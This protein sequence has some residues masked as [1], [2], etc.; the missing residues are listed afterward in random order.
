MNDL[1]EGMMRIV[2][3]PDEQRV[4][5]AWPTVPPTSTTLIRQTQMVQQGAN[6]ASPER[7]FSNGYS[8]STTGRIGVVNGASLDQVEVLTTSK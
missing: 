1:P 5:K 7:R 6:T 2:S 3:D 4:S 8:A